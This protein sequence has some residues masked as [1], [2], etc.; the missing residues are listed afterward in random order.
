MG[1]IDSIYFDGAK[2]LVIP[3]IGMVLRGAAGC[4][5]HESWRWLIPVCV[6]LGFKTIPTDIEECY[7]VVI[8]ALDELDKIKI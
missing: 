5:Y 1:S 6:K 4:K 7:K 8:T 3:E 2:G